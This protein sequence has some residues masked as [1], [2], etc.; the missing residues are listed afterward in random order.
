[1]SEKTKIIAL[2]AMVD[3]KNEKAILNLWPIFKEDIGTEIELDGKL[4]SVFPIDGLFLKDGEIID[5]DWKKQ[6]VIDG[7]PGKGMSTRIEKIHG[8]EVRFDSEE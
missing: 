3:V 5:E 1:M 6:I 8:V 2:Y 4:I 7:E